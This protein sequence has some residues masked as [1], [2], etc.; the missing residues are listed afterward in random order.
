MEIRKKES[1]ALRLRSKIGLTTR[2][3]KS[4]RGKEPVIAGVEKDQ[5]SE[6]ALPSKDQ[7]QKPSETVT[8]EDH[9]KVRQIS[10]FPAG[11][12][13]EDCEPPA[14]TV[15]ST[16]TCSRCGRDKFLKPDELHA[17]GA[18]KSF[19]CTTCRSPLICLP[20][21]LFQQVTS[22][23]DNTSL[24]LLRLTCSRIYATIPDTPNPR[25]QDHAI[26]FMVLI[27]DFISDRLEYCRECN[28]YHRWTSDVYY[29][30]SDHEKCCRR[31]AGA[32][33]IPSFRG[34]VL[35][36]GYY[37]CGTCN[38]RRLYNHCS[39]C[40]RCETCC[41]EKRVYLNGMDFY[42]AACNGKKIRCC[43][44]PILA[45]RA[46]HRCQRCEDCSGCKFGSGQTMCGLCRGH[47]WT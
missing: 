45:R 4:E 9:M 23:L 6:E 1:L 28:A 46:C 13:R 31:Y 32:D 3:S 36:R 43:G 14:Q 18:S 26:E 16:A 34:G 37:V 11:I 19:I 17:Q 24:W 25:H 35:G 2:K 41:G 7:R 12:I 40:M 29:R 20:L 44:R 10:S 33:G 30:W 42:C 22:Y 5:P 8:E 38:T 39:L 21:E 47:S 27:R 15:V